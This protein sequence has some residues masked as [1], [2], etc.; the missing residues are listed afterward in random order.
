MKL[1]L[2]ATY[3]ADNDAQLEQAIISNYPDNHYAIGRGQWM[4]AASGTATEVATTLGILPDRSALSGSYVFWVGE[5][6][7]RAKGDMGEWMDAKAPRKV[8]HLFKALFWHTKR[9]VIY[10]LL[11]LAIAVASVITVNFLL[12]LR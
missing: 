11:I 6:F 4:I 3:R 8:R 10:L 9:G 7:G 5:Y 1:F 12:S 2:V